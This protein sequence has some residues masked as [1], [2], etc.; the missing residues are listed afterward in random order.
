MALPQVVSRDEWLTARKAFLAEEKAFTQR[1]D[2]LNTSRRQLPMVKLDK[3]YTFTG[4]EGDVGLLDLFDGYRQLIVIHFMF[5]PDWDEGCPSCSAGA[6]ELAEG[7]LRHLHA[8]DTALVVV[9]RAP[10]EKLARFKAQKGWTFPW[11]SSFKSDFNY[12]FH[13][14]MD[15]AVAPVEYNYRDKAAHEQAG[16]AYYV[17]GEGAV[18]APGVSCLLRDGDDVFHTYSTYA[19]GT[20]ATGGAYYFLDLTALGRQEAWEEPQGRAIKSHDASPDFSA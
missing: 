15:E 14:T 11:Y 6:D 13:V 16:T 8:R 17:E 2:T 12:D 4:P 1:R 19:R 7:L 20:E 9:A 5:A 3:A 10:Y 18:E